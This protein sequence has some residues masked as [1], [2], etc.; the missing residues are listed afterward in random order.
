MSLQ[1]GGLK[2]KTLTKEGLSP[3]RDM[4]N[5]TGATLEMMTCGSLKGFMFVLTVRPENSEYFGLDGNRTRFTV[6][7]T[8]FILKLAVTAPNESDPIADYTDINKPVGHPDHII[9]KAPETED[10]FF[11]EAKLQQ[12]IWKSSIMG[13]R[14]EICPSIANLSFFRNADALKFLNFIYYKVHNPDSIHTLDF[15]HSVCQ[16]NP[17]YGIGMILMP[18]IER[19]VTL[20]EFL[21]IPRGQMFNDVQITD[22]SKQ[23]VYAETLAKI[24][25]LYIEGHVIHFDLHHKNALV[26]ITSRGEL[27]VVLIDFGRASNLNIGRA[28]DYMSRGEKHAWTRDSTTGKGA[29]AASTRH[30]PAPNDAAGFYDKCLNLCQKHTTTDADKE[31]FMKEIIRRVADMDRSKNQVMFGGPDYASHRYQ[32]DWLESIIKITTGVPTPQE[33]IDFSTITRLAFDALCRSV[34]VNVDAGNVGKVTL[35]TLNENCENFDGK[36]LNM[37]VMPFKL[38]RSEWSTSWIPWTARQFRK[39][40]GRGRMLKTKRHRTRKVKKSKSKKYKKYNKNF[41]NEKK[42]L[43]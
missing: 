27:K 10:S 37:F 17:T 43:A 1:I 39:M 13:G 14:E 25:R 28:D 22:N 3:V 4:I 7:V 23:L 30:R 34:I 11:E 21:R 33:Q 32:M 31:A 19:S 24:V 36:N 5:S 18:K 12:H 9:E 35:R 38:T 40:T 6:P 41:K 16:G 20:Y 8:S 15:L 29:S 42:M 2:K 26:Y